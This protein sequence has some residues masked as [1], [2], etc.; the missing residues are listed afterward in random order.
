MPPR[1]AALIQQIQ[2]AEQQGNAQL[3]TVLCSQLVHRFGVVALNTLDRVID[4]VEE[5]AGLAPPEAA[6]EAPSRAAGLFERFSATLRVRPEPAAETPSQPRRDGTPPLSTPR[7]LR[8]WLP[9]SQS[10]LDR[11]AS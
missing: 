9:G 3:K 2:D 11:Q 1:Q 7:S 4:D 5:A 6:E 8:R 10:D